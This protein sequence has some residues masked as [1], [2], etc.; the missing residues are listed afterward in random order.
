[1]VVFVLSN[2]CI[3][4]TSKANFRNKFEYSTAPL[5]T[6]FPPYREETVA[7]RTSIYAPLVVSWRDAENQLQPVPTAPSQ[8]VRIIHRYVNSCDDKALCFGNRLSFVAVI[9]VSV[10]DPNTDFTTCCDF[11]VLSGALC[12]VWA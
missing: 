4:Y 6:P 3:L 10:C 2:V 5:F 7:C 12:D 1:M 8:T 11:T 9:I